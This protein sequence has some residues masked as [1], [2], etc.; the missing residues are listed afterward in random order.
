LL[1]DAGGLFTGFNADDTSVTAY[2]QSTATGLGGGRR[3]LD[4]EGVVALPLRLS[5]NSN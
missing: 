1:D 3:S 4:A 5:L 2:P